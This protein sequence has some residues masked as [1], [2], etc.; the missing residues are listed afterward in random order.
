[1]LEHESRFQVI[2]KMGEGVN[3][4]TWILLS[5]PPLPRIFISLLVRSRLSFF[6][7]RAP[8]SPVT[9]KLTG[10]VATVISLLGKMV[11]PCHHTRNLKQ[12]QR[13]LVSTQNLR[14][15]TR[16]WT[17]SSSTF[18]TTPPPTRGEINRPCVDHK[19]T[20]LLQI[21]LM[22]CTN[23]TCIF[24]MYIVY[25]YYV[26]SYHIDVVFHWFIKCIIIL[27]IIKIIKNL[28]IF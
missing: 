23:L 22:R 1:M 5:K 14:Q 21:I 19:S 8:S 7:S 4:H 17:N 27:V 15:S 25:L 6:S 16:A 20:C 26:F 9:P 10:E 12:C 24:D 3:L 2:L 11:L 13:S 18:E 28:F